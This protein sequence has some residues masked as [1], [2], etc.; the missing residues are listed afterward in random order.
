MTGESTTP[1]RSSRPHLILWGILVLTAITSGGYAAW[2]L[3]PHAPEELHE[4]EDEL[5]KVGNLSFDQETS[6][7]LT[8]E[9]QDVVFWVGYGMAGGYGDPVLTKEGKAVRWQGRSMSMLDIPK[10][11]PL[12]TLISSDPSVEH[13]EAQ[14]IADRL[15]CFAGTLQPQRV[16]ARRQ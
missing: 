10:I 15:V 1:Q 16:F 3:W 4:E 13:V 14:E 5:I 7:Q 11:K 12:R 2:S 6:L 9:P 8:A